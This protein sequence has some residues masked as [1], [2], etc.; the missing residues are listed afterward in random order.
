MLLRKSIATPT[1]LLYFEGLDKVVH[2][3]IFAF[4]GFIF[5][6]AFRRIS[7]IIFF[8]I[9]TSYGFVTEVLQHLMALG[10][11]MEFSDLCADTFGG[12]LGYFISVKFLEIIKKW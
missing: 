8:I 5:K 11:S 9:V 7:F 4:L 12:V 3:L 10:R 2:I 1:Q 6:V